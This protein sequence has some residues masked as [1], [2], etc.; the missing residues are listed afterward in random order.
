MIGE[1]LKTL[2]EEKGWSQADLAKKLDISRMTVN[3]YEAGKRTP[4]VDVAIKATEL[5]GVSADYLLGRSSFRNDEEKQQANKTLSDLGKMINQVGDETS[6]NSVVIWF[7]HLVEKTLK[8]NT[9]RENIRL[10]EQ[11]VFALYRLSE[12]YGET[13]SSIRSSKA[14]ISKFDVSQTYADDILDGLPEQI[15]KQIHIDEKKIMEAY[16]QLA[17]QYEIKLENAIK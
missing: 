9:H 3:Y 6:I 11:L 12:H 14:A 16:W 2:R 8:I 13:R 17:E 7:T 15:Y 5:F 4:D 1:R 10:V